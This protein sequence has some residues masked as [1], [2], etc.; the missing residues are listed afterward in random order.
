MFRWLAVLA[1]VLVMFTTV[2]RADESNEAMLAG[3]AL[4]KYRSAA[5][6]LAGELYF[7]QGLCD[8]VQMNQITDENYELGLINDEDI[9]TAS[10]VLAYAIWRIQFVI[11]PAVTSVLDEDALDDPVLEP[12]VVETVAVCEYI[13]AATD[14]FMEVSDFEALAFYAAAL[15]E[16]ECALDLMSLAELAADMAGVEE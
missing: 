10:L 12:L 16:G 13:R 1:V 7:I 4:G 11:E 15:E 3:Y 2:P 8:E 6:M 5:V 9:E 14:G